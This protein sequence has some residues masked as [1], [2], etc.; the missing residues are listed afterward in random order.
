MSRLNRW[1]IAIAT[2]VFGWI[3]SSGGVTYYCILAHARGQNVAM[4]VTVTGTISVV[5]AGGGSGKTSNGDGVV[6][7]KATTSGTSGNG[8]SAE[9][10]VPHGQHF[11]ILQEHKKFNP[12]V[13]AV[14]VG[15]VVD[16]PN[17]D[18]FF[19]NVFSL[20]EGKRFDL[21]LYEAGTSH[22]VTFDSPGICYIFC[23]I[24]PEMSAAVVVVDSPWYAMSNQAGQFSI[25]NVPPGSYLLY[26]W[27]ER[28]KPEKPGDFP[29]EV[30]I[31]P[32]NASLPIIRLVDA[33]DLFA[34]HKNKYG[35]DYDHDKSL[36]PV[37]K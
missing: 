29:R 36:S 19:H 31:T 2:L 21:G 5:R 11:K 25:P 33:G 16:F 18:P 28:G 17:L 14:P 22:A 7:L 26:V 30:T 12:H 10:S 8:R 9:R 35:R 32:G 1:I 13:L 20:F 23:N 15:A 34:N 3:L 37:Y 6:W 4:T 24:H 27:H